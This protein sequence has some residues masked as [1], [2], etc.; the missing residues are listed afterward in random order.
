MKKIAKNYFA[1]IMLAFAFVLAVS[2]A[3]GTDVNAATVS[4]SQVSAY[5]TSAKIQWN[6]VSGAAGYKITL[7]NSSKTVAVKTETES[8]SYTYENF[9]GLTSGTS[10]IAKVEAYSTKV[11]YST[12]TGPLGSAEIE[13]VTAPSLSSGTNYN[14][15]SIASGKTTLSYSAVSGANRYRAEYYS[16]SD[17]SKKLSA[18]SNSA[19]LTVSGLKTNQEYSCRVYAQRVSSTGFVAESSYSMSL[20]TDKVNNYYICGLPSLQGSLD[21]T[22]YS[23]SKKIN[24]GMTE[25]TVTANGYEFKLYDGKKKIKSFSESSRYGKTF[26]SKYAS[27]NKV[28]KAVVRA[29]TY[30]STGKKYYTKAKTFYCSKNCDVTKVT[31]KSKKITAK[32]TKISGADRYVVYAVKGNKNGSYKKVATVKGS[33]ASATFSKLGKSKLTKGKTY[34]VYVIAQ[35]KVN[36]KYVSVSDDYYCYKVK[37]K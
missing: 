18:Y 26:S 34:Y 29:Y 12:Y 9:S 1:K 23:A 5:D 35:K 13:V 33:K 4:V 30:D 36:G 24:L 27:K 37:V 15:S 2:F 19:S 31:S 32:W 20:N 10:Y 8:A 14:V 16:T 7:Y 21:Y 28:Y 25:N 17:T 11:N 3:H 22:F 6:T